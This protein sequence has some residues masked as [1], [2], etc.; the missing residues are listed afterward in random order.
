[1]SWSAYWKHYRNFALFRS[2]KFA[3]LKNIQPYR[4]LALLFTSLLCFAC[5]IWLHA[6]EVFPA[7]TPRPA[8]MDTAVTNKAVIED[9]VKVAVRDSTEK[10]HSPKKAALLSAVCPGLGQIY[11]GKHWYWKVPLIY[12][13]FTGLG[14]AIGINASRHRVFSNAYR[15]A[16]NDSLISSVEIDGQRYSE[17]Q[18]VDFKNYYKRNRDIAIIFTAAIYALNIIDA[19][20]F[21]HLFYFDKEINEKISLS[22]QPEYSLPAFG[23]GAYG[24]IKISLRL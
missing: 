19:A 4:L 10:K 12:G 3:Q 8:I 6:Q 11:N 21:A 9:T 23:Q 18:L 22:I 24:G 20:V 16:A 5:P 15:L 1:M 2:I 17:S 14:F 7:D 13:G